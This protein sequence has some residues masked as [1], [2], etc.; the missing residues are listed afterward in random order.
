M[1]GDHVVHKR[2]VVLGKEFGNDRLKDWVLS[3]RA[4][5]TQSPNYY[6][7]NEVINTNA[8]HLANLRVKIADLR[9]AEIVK[10]CEW[11][12]LEGNTIP[13]RVRALVKNSAKA[14]V[15]APAAPN[16]KKELSD[17]GFGLVSSA[18]DRVCGGCAFVVGEQAYTTRAR[19]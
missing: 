19:P 6:E 1:S 2:W 11:E 8:R 7:P 10:L 3:R 17:Q 12:G 18:E 4:L 13:A 9:D 5:S 15:K 16:L 14:G